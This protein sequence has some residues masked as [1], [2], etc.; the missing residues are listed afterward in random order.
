MKTTRRSLIQKSDSTGTGAVPVLTT[1]GAHHGVQSCMPVHHNVS[2]GPKVSNQQLNAKQLCDYDDLCTMMIVDS[3]LGFTTH[4]MN[5]R[6]RPVNKKLQATWKAIID[7]FKATSDYTKAS[8]LLMHNKWFEI[9]FGNGNRYNQ[10]AKHAIKQ[11]MYNFL[12]LFSAD[13]GVTINECE[14]FTTE[15]KGGMI[16]ATKE[17]T[18]GEKIELLVG[19]IA[20]MNKDEELQIL[21]QGLN[22]FSVMY[23]CRKQC[24]QLWLGPAAYINHDCRPN[25]KFVSTGSSSAC[26]E[27]LRDIDNNEEITCFYDENFFGENNALCECRTCERFVMFYVRIV[28]DESMIFWLLPDLSV[29]KS[30]NCP[31]GTDWLF[32]NDISIIKFPNK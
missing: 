16:V 31:V 7:D 21:K 3:M 14:R 24:S 22:D 10:N 15:K 8:D 30:E 27:V 4:K 26:V 18:K 29:I 6:F 23:S 1:N 11:H 12:H 2:N 5:T 32:S 13:S 28:F 19:C 17:W 20:E 9:N 25:C